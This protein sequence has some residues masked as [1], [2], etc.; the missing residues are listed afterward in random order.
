MNGVVETTTPFCYY[1]MIETHNLR[2]YCVL[3]ILNQE[4]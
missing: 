2:L 3:I 4:M 1:S